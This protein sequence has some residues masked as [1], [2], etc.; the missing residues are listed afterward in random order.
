MTFSSRNSFG[1]IAAK[2]VTA[3]KYAIP[4]TIQGIYNT[5]LGECYLARGDTPPWNDVLALAD[6][7]SYVLGDVPGPVTTLTAGADVS[8]YEIQWVVRGWVPSED[9][10]M[11]SYLIQRGVIYGD[12]DQDE[13]WEDFKEA[14]VEAKFDG[15]KV[16]LV[17]IDSAH[18]EEKVYAFCLVNDTCIPTKGRDTMDCWWKASKPEVDTRGKTKRFGLKLWHINSDVTKSW[19]YSRIKASSRGETI[20]HIPANIDHEYC[21]QVASE[22]RMVDPR[23]VVFWKKHRA[24][25]FLDCESLSWFGA[26]QIKIKAVRPVPKVLRKG[27]R[28]VSGDQW[29]AADPWLS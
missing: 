5:L 11:E 27:S 18:R 20:W 19:V 21:K 8:D 9:G 23:G 7:E 10:L 22:S 26:N 28:A 1:H 13:T 29:Q 15:L 24:N 17:A 25:H 16:D 4:A 3:L 2:L 14:V 12:T 6:G